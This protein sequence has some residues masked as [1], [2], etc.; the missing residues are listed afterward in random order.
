MNCI[1]NSLVMKGHRGYSG[2]SNDG[3]CGD[4][5]TP[6]TAVLTITSAAL[7]AAASPGAAPAGNRAGHAAAVTRSPRL[8]L[9]VLSPL[10]E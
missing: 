10:C 6:T 1:D 2:L 5:F 4:A 3:G 8:H 7:T 9:K